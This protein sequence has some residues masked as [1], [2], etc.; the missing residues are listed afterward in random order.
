VKN[1]VVTPE[2]ADGGGGLK[3]KIKRNTEQKR[4]GGIEEPAGKTQKNFGGLV[5]TGN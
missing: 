5:I 2:S 4:D 1:A 3:I